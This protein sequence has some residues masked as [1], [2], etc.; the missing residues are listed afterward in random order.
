MNKAY[1]VHYKDAEGRYR[2]FCTY[3]SSAYSVKCSA[4]ELLP[5]QSLITRIVPVDNFDW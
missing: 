3:G 5:K 2:I 1:E 4:D